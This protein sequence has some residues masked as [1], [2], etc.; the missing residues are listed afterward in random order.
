MTAVTVD[1]RQVKGSNRSSKKCMVFTQIERCSFPILT[2]V[3]FPRLQ[4]QEN[5]FA[6]VKILH[7][8]VGGQTD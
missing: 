6:R 3:E 7:A 5:A 2:K 8:A 1:S 4:F